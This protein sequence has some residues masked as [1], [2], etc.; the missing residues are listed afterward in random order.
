MKMPRLLLSLSFGI[1]AV[2]ALGALPC[3]VASS[4]DESWAFKSCVAAC[5]HTGCAAI[6][7]DAN[8]NGTVDYCS[9]LCDPHSPTPHFWLDVNNWDCTSDCS[10]RCMWL[11]EDPKTIQNTEGRIEKYFGKWPFV[12]VFGAQEPASVITSQANLAA[13]M[14]CLMR[15]AQQIKRSS[16]RLPFSAKIYPW[17][18]L[19]HFTLSCNAWLWSS[20]FHCRDTKTTE[21][22]DYF[23]AGFLVA[24]N[25]F[26]SIARVVGL[27]SAKSLLALAAPIF[28]LYLFHIHHML[29]VLFD[30]GF[31]V[32]LC[33]GAGAIQTAAWLIWVLRSKKGRNH[34]GR[35]ALFSFMASLNVAML[36]EILDFP[37]LWKVL[38]AHA[39]WH[40]ATAPLTLVWYAFVAADVVFFLG[41]IQEHLTLKSSQKIT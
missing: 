29:A 17:L 34:P 13:N 39:L 19:G 21:R 31:H 5:R 15:T 37:P 16:H 20:I 27:N 40:A 33:V 10:Y 12:R 9:P 18:W 3:A 35:R 6:T 1:A 4:G 26:L 11:L 28:T 7:T 23:S 41:Q 36:L 2:V 30:Y 8:L 24:Y 22:F 25:L 38:D 14:Y 32:G